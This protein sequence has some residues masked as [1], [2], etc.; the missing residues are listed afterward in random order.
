MSGQELELVR[1][2]PKALRVDRCKAIDAM[3]A[4]VGKGDPAYKALTDEYYQEIRRAE[5]LLDKLRAS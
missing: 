1:E 3:K 4:M 2:G 5:E